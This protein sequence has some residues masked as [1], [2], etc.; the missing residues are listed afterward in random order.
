MK[1]FLVTTKEGK[2]LL[3]SNTS[4]FKVSN[5]VKASGSQPT[6]VLEI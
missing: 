4:P 3:V 1:K 2:T 5:S 6:L